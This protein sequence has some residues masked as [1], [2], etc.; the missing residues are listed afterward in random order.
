MLRCRAPFQSETALPEAN[1]FP[2]GCQ[3]FCCIPIGFFRVCRGV[4]RR[5][6]HLV[7]VGVGGGKISCWVSAGPLG[8]A[9]FDPANVRQYPHTVA[10]KSAIRLRPRNYAPGDRAGQQQDHFP[11]ESRSNLVEP[12]VNGR[13]AGK[14]S[15]ETERGERRGQ[16]Q[17]DFP[18]EQPAPCPRARLPLAHAYPCRP[19]HRVWPAPQGPPR[20]ICLI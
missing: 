2:C 5:V 16:G 9:K 1:S 6:D 8:Q 14:A 11:T 17:A 19:C 7:P 3:Q 15:S 13:M 4:L 20:A 12:N 10:R 18:A